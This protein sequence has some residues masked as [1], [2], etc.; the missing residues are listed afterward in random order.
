MIGIKPSHFFVFSEL[1]RI[2]QERPDV[3]ILEMGSG[4]SRD[5][6]RLLEKFPNLNYV[7]VEPNI[8]FVEKARRSL[9]LFKNT[10]IIHALGYDTRAVQEYG[11][12]DVV[13]SLSVLEHVKYPDRFL[14]MSAAVL[15]EGGEAIHQYDLEKMF[16]SVCV[17]GT[18]RSGV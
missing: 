8:A 10:H 13:F 14:K 3:R 11:P 16:P 2:V 6:A 7:G 15:K 12:F 1:E 4:W 18:R 5:M 9:S 17:W